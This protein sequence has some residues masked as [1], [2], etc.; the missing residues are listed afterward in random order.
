MFHSQNEDE[1]IQLSRR[2][3]RSADIRNLG[4]FKTRKV[5]KDSRNKRNSYK[6]KPNYLTRLCQ[7]RKLY[8]D[9]GDLGW[10]DWVIAPVGYTANYCYGEC[11]YPMNS[12]MNATNHA[13]IQTL[14]HSLNSSYVPKPCCAPIK[15]STQSVLYIDDN[16]NIVLKFYKNMVVR[17]CGCL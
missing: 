8:V 4:E 9:F 5:R 15:L 13:I 12:Y 11:T 2:K 6:K 16:S 10:E 1:R 17:A 7:R 14:A 3:K